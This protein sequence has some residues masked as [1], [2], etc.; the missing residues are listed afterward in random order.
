MKGAV[1]DE[2]RV[3]NPGDTDLQGRRR[4][5]R[6]RRSEKANRELSAKKQPA[7]FEAHCEYLSAWEED[8]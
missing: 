1:I 3:L 4:R 5:C 7:E 2:V 6:A 8:K